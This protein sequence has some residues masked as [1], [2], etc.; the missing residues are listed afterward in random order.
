MTGE[1]VTELLYGKEETEDRRKKLT[2]ER[3]CKHK[4]LIFCLLFPV[5]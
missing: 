5:F 4:T 3:V 1:I 2:D